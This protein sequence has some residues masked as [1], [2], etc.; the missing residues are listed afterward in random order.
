M[1]ASAPAGDTPGDAGDAHLEIDL[2][3]GGKMT[4][5][6]NNADLAGYSIRSPHSKIAPDADNLATPFLFYLLNAPHE[7]TTGTVGATTM[8]T[9]NLPLDITFAGSFETAQNVVFEYTR[10]GEVTPVTGV[11]H[12]VPEPA[13]VILLA[14]GRFLMTRPCHRFT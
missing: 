13:T 4:L 9:A 14:A 2:T 3:D 1:F 10:A 12:I 11:V 7:V 5:Q 6:P 8:L